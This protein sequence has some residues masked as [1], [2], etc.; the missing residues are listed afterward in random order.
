MQFSPA[1]IHH[2]LLWGIAVGHC[3]DDRQRAQEWAHSWVGG[4]IAF[5]SGAR[6]SH[7]LECLQN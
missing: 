7:C 1:A 3:I 5:P 6:G 4:L 2:F